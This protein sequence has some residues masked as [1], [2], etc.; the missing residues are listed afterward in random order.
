MFNFNGSTP[1]KINFN[2]KHVAK[3]IFN[4]VV[5]W[6]GKVL[7]TITGYPIT[8]T[9]STGEDLVDYKIYGNSIQDGTPTPDT[10]IEIHSVGDKTSNM[11]DYTK[12]SDKT[13]NG[14][15]YTNN[16]NGKF[17][18]NGTLTS[19]LSSFSFAN[20]IDFTDIKQGVEYYGSCG[21]D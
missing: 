19:T 18:A 7:T 16:N 10:P 15:T 6:V 8:L 14:I 3:V 13:L 12:I 21:N 5:V 4:N 20:S 2:G 9:N 1:K 17:I 11:I